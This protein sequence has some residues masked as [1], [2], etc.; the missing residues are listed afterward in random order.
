MIFYKV[1]TFRNSNRSKVPAHVN[2]GAVGLLL[3]PVVGLS[4]S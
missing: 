2:S 3:P 4:L 1:S